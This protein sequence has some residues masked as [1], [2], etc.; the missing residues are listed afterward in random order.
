MT[1]G[2]LAFGLGVA[3]RT[4]DSQ[5]R[6]IDALRA[7]VHTLQ[8]GV[9]AEPNWSAVARRVEPSVF[10]IDTSYGLGSGWVARSNAS[11]SELVTNFHVVEEAWSKG[12]VAVEVSQG[13]RT[14]Q[15]TIASVD[16]NDDLAVIHVAEILPALQ[17]ARNRPA[18]AQAVMVLGS[19]LGLGGS[20]S[21]GVISGFHS[22]DGSDWVQFSAPISPGNSGGPVVDSRGHVVAVAAAKFVGEGVEALS[23]GIP[24]QIACAQAVKCSVGN[25]K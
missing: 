1:A 13:D 19:P 4:I 23:L 17:T 21:V 2:A 16:P 3:M 6:S 24:V 20:V 22:I 15:G 25:D 8:A 11:G 10:T 7:K 18:V 12:V 9:D 5:A 14:I